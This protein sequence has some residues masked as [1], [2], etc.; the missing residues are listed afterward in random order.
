[1]PSRPQEQ[2]TTLYIQCRKEHV[3]LSLSIMTSVRSPKGEKPRCVN[4]SKVRLY[5]SVFKPERFKYKNATIYVSPHR[6]MEVGGEADDMG[7][8][9]TQDQN[10]LLYVFWPDVLFQPLNALASSG[11]IL[12]VDASI[13]ALK[14]GNATVRSLGFNTQSKDD[15]D[16]EFEYW[17]ISK[18]RGKKEQ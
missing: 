9:R 17:F 14:R 3:D 12:T 4:L 5:G 15:Y 10:I 13:S 7:W 11:R 1:M 8:A 6:G 18:P 16:A 2:S